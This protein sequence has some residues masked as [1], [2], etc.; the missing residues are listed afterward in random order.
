MRVAVAGAGI[1]GL[2]LALALRRRGVDVRVFEQA[3]VVTEIGA[4]VALGANSTRL[5]DALGLHDA[6]ERVGYVPPDIVF[7]HGGDG[8]EV[9]RH[10]LDEPY[11]RRFGGRFYGLHRRDLQRVLLDA[12]GADVVHTGR[13]AV[14]VEQDDDGARLVLERGE[15]ADADVVVAADGV[16]SALRAA[17]AAGGEAVFS[18][19][20]GYRGMIPVERLPSLPDAGSC[21]FWMGPGRHLLHYPIHGGAVVNFL[22]VVR[23][24]AWTAERWMERCD[25]ADAVAAFAGWHPAVTEMVG[26]APEGARWALFERRPLTRWSHRRVVLLGDAAHAMLPHQGQGAGQTVED[27]VA[28]ADCL[29]DAGPGRHAEAFARYEAARLRRTRRVQAASRRAA[30]TLHL[31]A[32]PEADARDGEL[33]ALDEA[34]HWIH[35]HDARAA[36]SPAGI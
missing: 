4:G 1:G 36:G 30:D 31:P 19:C 21:Q 26:A 32:G 5:L 18:G 28:L 8:A 12:V 15:A 24:P 3:D 34:L 16:H 9:A 22:A 13:R 33:P 23:T 35:A 14:G 10:R 27:A 2:T 20:V 11:E 17:V 7:R 29:A 25:P 6:L